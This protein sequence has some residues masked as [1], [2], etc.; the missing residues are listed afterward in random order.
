LAADE[1]T[2]PP[3]TQEGGPRVEVVE[4]NFNF[5]QMER[6]REKSH[7]FAI[8]NTGDAPLTLSVGQTSCKCTLSKVK[9]GA[10]APGETTHV[11]L[12]WS[13]KA[14]HGP[15]RQT[16]TII[17][18][19]PRQPEV[20]LTID[21]EVV[22]ATGVQP[23]DLG[24]DKIAVG[25]TK[26]AEVYVMAMIQDELTV[27][28]AELSDA[29]TREKFDIKIEPVERDQL[30]VK[31]ARDGVRVTLTTKPGLPIGRFNQ[32]L[33]LNTNLQEGEKLHIPVIGRVVGDI[34]VHGPRGI[35]LE[36][37]GILNL[38]RVESAV[39]KKAR[40]NLMIRG[41]GAERVK[42]EIGLADPPELKI[43][44]GEPKRLN[45]TLVRVPM[46]IE[47]PPGTRP[48]ARLSASQG[49]EG[50]IV[51]KT[52]HPTVKEFALGVR[53]SVER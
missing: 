10:I 28:S 50:K 25:E 45:A 13:A 15:F 32:F 23:P 4:P 9:S 2:P 24:F 33:T 46:E 40:L 53:F 36:E 26:S 47:V 35:W 37:Q 20:T 43:T 16:A 31:T 21:G 5:G 12:E 48:M 18:N 1:S 34:S 3:T 44:F 11:R 14:D 49:E 30:P 22:A 42:F 39:G 41:E 27:S 51:L 38:G 52:T 8:R 29:E 7:E 6:G 17:T 19:D